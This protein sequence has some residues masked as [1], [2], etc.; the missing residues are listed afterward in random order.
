MAYPNS[1][2]KK[3]CGNATQKQGCMITRSPFCAPSLKPAQTTT[4]SSPE[5]RLG[6]I[7][8]PQP[9]ALCPSDKKTALRRITHL[10]PRKCA[11]PDL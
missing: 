6:S 5:G 2:Q 1:L 11:L 7:Q 4:A 3:H 9:M 8:T 10:M